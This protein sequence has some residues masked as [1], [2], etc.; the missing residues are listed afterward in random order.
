MLSTA[1]C[2][3]ITI[4]GG[5]YHTV[6][7]GYFVVFNSSAYLSQIHIIG[8]WELTATSFSIVGSEF[9]LSKVTLES[10]FQY[11]YFLIT[12]SSG[13][14]Q[15][16]TI[17]ELGQIGCAFQFASANITIQTALFS[18]ASPITMEKI[19]ILTFGSK[20]HVRL[21]NATLEY[22]PI[23]MLMS[24]SN[25]VCLFQNVTVRNCAFEVEFIRNVNSDIELRSVILKYLKVGWLLGSSGRISLIDS[26]LVNI[27]ASHEM[28][29]QVA[30][31]I[32]VQNSVIK[33][34]HTRL[35]Y[36]IF[37]ENSK[38]SIITSVCGK[39]YLQTQRKAL[40]FPMGT[41]K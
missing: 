37:K 16:L 35:T 34:C 36:G 1:T 9:G 19:C 21:I 27:E 14:M 3:N 39:I 30:G 41:W 20:S 8:N 15:D 31:A 24:V 32:S 11:S 33:N 6:E 29:Q 12:R 18:E 7:S 13:Y 40:C 28:F 2:T 17:R 22:I 5:G 10:I 4:I 38:L 26:T 23:V 25:S